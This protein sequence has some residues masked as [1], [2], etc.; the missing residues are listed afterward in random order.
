[1]ITNIIR[2]IIKDFPSVAN[3]KFD[4]VRLLPIGSKVELK[5]KTPKE[6]TIV[7]SN[8]PQN[9]NSVSDYKACLIVDTLIGSD[10]TLAELANEIDDIINSDVALW[11][12]KD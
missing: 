8:I 3:S 10:M 2:N 5:V 1:M 11:D 9:T 12:M 6:L 7:V 4:S